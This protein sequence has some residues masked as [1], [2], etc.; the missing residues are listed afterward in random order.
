MLVSNIAIAFLVR[1]GKPSGF[2]FYY[3]V[4]TI[5]PLMIFF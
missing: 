1:L 4:D 2:K 3:Y 5:F